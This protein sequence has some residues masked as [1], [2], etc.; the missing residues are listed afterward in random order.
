MMKKLVKKMRPVMNDME[1][2]QVK[3][4]IYSDLE[5]LAVNRDYL[6]MS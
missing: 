2:R 5:M 3:L 4:L 1:F 6:L